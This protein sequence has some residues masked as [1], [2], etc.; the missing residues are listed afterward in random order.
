MAPRRKSDSPAPASRS[1]RS[2]RRAV[3]GAPAVRGATG[4]MRERVF[5][6]V[7]ARLSLGEPP[8]VREVQEALGLSAIESARGHLERLVRDGRLTK[9]EGIARGY[10]LAESELGSATKRTSAL[11]SPSTPNSAPSSAS[12][13]APGSPAG[14]IVYVPAVLHVPIV[15]RVAAGLLSEAIEDADGHVTVELG[16]DSPTPAARAAARSRTLF[17]LR[18]RGESMRDAA[19]LHGDVVIVERTHEVHDGEIVV[20]QVDGEATVKTLR[21]RGGGPGVPGVIELVPANPDF[22]TLRFAPGASGTS[23]EI[24]GRVL[25]VR[26]YLKPSRAPRERA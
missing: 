18:V 8:T 26:R 14:S 7:R 2:I 3:R 15:G 5:D 6:F 21:R 19:I 4:A 22:E 13:F 25:E 12:M 16:G 1:P 24:L 17:A 11:R 23:L 9:T 20:A 10:R